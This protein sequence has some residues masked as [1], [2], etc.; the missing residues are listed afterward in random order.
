MFHSFKGKQSF[1]ENCKSRFVL[2]MTQ[3]FMP[4]KLASYD[5]VNSETNQIAIME[6]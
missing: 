5:I 6:S 1:V 3:T 4:Q 2:P